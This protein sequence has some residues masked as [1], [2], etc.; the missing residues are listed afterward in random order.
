MHLTLIGLGW[1]QEFASLYPSYFDAFVPVPSIPG[2]HDPPFDLESFENALQ[3]L[4]SQNFDVVIQMHGSGPQSNIVA[5]Q[6]PAR[7]HAGYRSVGE[8]ARPDELSMPYPTAGSEVQRNLALVQSIGVGD[9]DESLELPIPPESDLR[10]ALLLHDAGIEG[11]YVCLHPGAK[12]PS[13]RWPAE[14]FAS[15]AAGLEAMGNRV[16]VTG[17]QAEAH[18]ARQVMQAVRRGIDLTGKTDL[19]CLAAVVKRASLVVCNDTGVSHVAVAVGTPT[20]VVSSGSDAARWATGGAARHVTLAVDIECRPCMHAT[21][22]IG[23]PCALAVTPQAVLG[24][25]DSLLR[26]RPTMPV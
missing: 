8:A 6:I 14:R 11:P 20:V 22:P 9:S 16:V 19:A 4:R 17:T 12:L 25:A 10:A 15:V 13:R 1:A 7:H 5:R 3:T 26:S 24:H 23:H 21:C 2:L 18:L